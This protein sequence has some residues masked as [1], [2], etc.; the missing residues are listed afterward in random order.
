MISV[1]QLSESLLPCESPVM[2]MM[3]AVC[4]FAVDLLVLMICCSFIRRNQP[5]G[6]FLQAS[7]GTCARKGVNR[8]LLSSY[9]P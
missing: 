3:V 2:M 8:H 1:L 5:F 9:K 7:F 4:S 6:Q